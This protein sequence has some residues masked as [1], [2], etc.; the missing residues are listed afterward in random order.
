M[1]YMTYHQILAAGASRRRNRRIFPS[2]FRRQITSTHLHKHA[3][4]ISQACVTHKNMFSYDNL[5]YR[6]HFNGALIKFDWQFS[7]I[8]LYHLQLRNFFF[9]AGANFWYTRSILWDVVMVEE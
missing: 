3:E 9:S 7:I 6:K 4:D 5:Q 2:L 8:A 1:K